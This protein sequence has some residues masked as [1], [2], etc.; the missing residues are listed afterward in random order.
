M[1]VQR[2]S[3]VVICP[4]ADCNYAHEHE[5]S[6]DGLQWTCFTCGTLAC[7]SCC[8]PWHSNETCE[9]YM[10]RTALNIEEPQIVEGGSRRPIVRCPSCKIKIQKEKGCD[11]MKCRCGAEFCYGC[12]AYYLSAQTE[13]WQGFLTVRHEK[14]CHRYADF[15]QGHVIEGLSWSE[16]WRRNGVVEFGSKHV[17][18]IVT[19]A[20]DGK[21]VSVSYRNRGQRLRL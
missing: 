9:Q 6:E 13:G 2:M 19:F 16:L 7:A 20:K 8:A 1:T 18:W 3:N 17:D 10:T 14:T 12:R 4:K 21:G 11:H 15:L 5:V